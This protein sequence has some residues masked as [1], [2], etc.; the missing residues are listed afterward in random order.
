MSPGRFKDAN[1]RSWKV[2]ARFS[3]LTF[4]RTVT[5][6]L[7]CTSTPVSVCTTAVT[8]PCACLAIRITSSSAPIG[9]PLVGPSVW[10]LSVTGVGKDAVEKKKLVGQPLLRKNGQYLRL[11]AGLQLL[12]R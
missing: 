6:T 4:I 1:F 10:A 11:G 9:A 7:L 8:A 3:D 5:N 2:R 12:D